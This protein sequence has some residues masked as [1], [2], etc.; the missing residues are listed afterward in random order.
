MKR[1][2]NDSLTNSKEPAEKLVKLEA[3]TNNPI[4]CGAY[5][6]CALDVQGRVWIFGCNDHGQLGPKGVNAQ[7]YI[8]QTIASLPS[9][10]KI[11]S[12]GY[13]IM[14]LDQFGNLFGWGKN[15]SNQIS[16]VELKKI[17][18]PVPLTGIPM[19]KEIWC[20]H[21]HTIALDA[22]GVLWSWGLN[23]HGQLGRGGTTSIPGIIPDIGSVR[24][25][26]CGYYHNIA[27]DSNSYLWAWGNNEPGQL[28][29]CNLLIILSCSSVDC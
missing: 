27:I 16:P 5:H 19:I 23:E 2:R 20:G 24:S 12:G 11:S 3:H 10:V 15:D 6:T 18:N 21:Q 25:V 29:R 28:G 4:S 26:H 13:H 22:T 17:I 8:P 1:T 9:I 7:T 14:A